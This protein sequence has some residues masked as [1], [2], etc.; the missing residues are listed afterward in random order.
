MLVHRFVEA[1]KDGSRWVQVAEAK[2]G[3]KSHEIGLYH[4]KMDQA[5]DEL[6]RTVGMSH[7]TASGIVDRL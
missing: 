5:I 6:S 4:G 3:R 2:G 1:S 7:S